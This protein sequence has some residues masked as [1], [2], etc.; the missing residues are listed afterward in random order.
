MAL[1]INQGKHDTTQDSRFEPIVENNVLMQVKKITLSDRLPNSL[2]IS[3]QILNGKHKN[4]FIF[5]TVTFDPDSLWAWKYRALR[6]SAGVPYNK[7]ESTKIDIE[8][9]LM[10]KAVTADLSVRKSNKPDDDR[11]FQNVTYKVASATKSAVST[12]KKAD[13]NE[14]AVD[15][16]DLE[17]MDDIEEEV[18]ELDEGEETED[19]S[20]IAEEI[21]DFEEEVEELEEEEEEEE[22][23]PTPKKTKKKT[24]T[25]STK[26]KAAKKAPKPV[27]EDNLPDTFEEEDS[28]TID[29]DDDEWE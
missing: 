5:D 19:V 18:V 26:T 28:V 15:L 8:T 25:L 11:E 23:A 22:P 14:K 24:A 7:G 9:L 6:K 29:D 10:N 16:D 12:T 13:A 4:R 1:V 20:E 2:D 21:E 27:V 3:F 17:G